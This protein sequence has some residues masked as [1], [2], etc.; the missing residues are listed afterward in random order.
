MALFDQKNASAGRKREAE[1]Q[2]P[3]GWDRGRS[4]SAG[5]DPKRQKY[6][7]QHAKE[8]EADPYEKKDLKKLLGLEGSIIY[9]LTKAGWVIVLDIIWLLTC[10]PVFTI[11]TA[12]TSLYYAMMK[13]IRRDRGYPLSE[14]FA[15]FKRTFA[16]GSILT[17]CI[18][19][20]LFLLYHLYTLAGMQPAETGMFLKRI[21][22]ALIAVTFAVVLY[23]FPVLS[24]FTMKLSMMVKL[25]FVMAFRYIGYT[26][27]MLIGTGLIIWAWLFYLPM[28]TIF[29][30][31]GAWCFVCTFMIE[32]ALRK[33]MPAP[34]KDEDAW[35]YE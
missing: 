26:L 29:F 30:L 3:K 19:I 31:P 1:T 27:L 34:G 12:S 23:L 35:Y 21:Y 4:K 9:F 6:Q 15:S 7:A 14:Y 11:G 16:S 25:A 20:W 33:Y 22:L 2:N 13:N 24:R 10:I 18:G 28:P 5:Q 17:V 32:K 8:K